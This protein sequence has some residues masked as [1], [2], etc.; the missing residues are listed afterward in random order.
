MPR[1]N[2]VDPR[3]KQLKDHFAAITQ[4]PRRA[5]HSP[6]VAQPNLERLLVALRLQSDHLALNPDEQV[7]HIGKALAL[8]LFIP[9]YQ[10]VPPDLALLQGLVFF[11][12]SYL[13]PISAA[14]PAPSIA[15]VITFCA[16]VSHAREFLRQ[17]KQ[18][19]NA[20]DTLDLETLRALHSLL[21]AEQFGKIVVSGLPH[22]PSDSERRTFGNY[23]NAAARV[24]AL[25][26]EALV[27]EL[28]EERAPREEDHAATCFSQ[29]DAIIP[30]LDT[31]TIKVAVP[32]QVMW[33][34]E[35]MTHASARLPGLQRR[36]LPTMCFVERRLEFQKLRGQAHAPDVLAGASAETM[37]MAGFVVGELGSGRTAF[38]RFLTRQ[39][40]GQ[41]LRHSE[42][43]LPFYFSAGEYVI[44]ARNRRSIHDYIAD[45]LLSF[46]GETPGIEELPDLLRA[47]ERAGKLLL[48]IDDLDRLSEADQS[49]VLAQL[50]FS[51]AVLCA[52]LPWQV[53]RLAQSNTRAHLGVTSF[54]P[55][56]KDEQLALLEHVATV[57]DV[58]YDRRT[59]EELLRELPA[60]AQTP[61]GVM[62]MLDQLARDW[63]D[64]TRVAGAALDELCRR[65]GLPLAPFEGQDAAT[66]TE[67]MHL[68]SAA[69]DLLFTLQRVNGYAGLNGQCD[70]TIV[71]EM[72]EN[73]RGYAW[74]Q[75]WEQ[76]RHTGLF[77]PIPRTTGQ[78][79][80]LIHRDLTCYLLAHAARH[81][82]FAI[83]WRGRAL[84]P[85]A[86]AMLHQV[87]CHLERLKN[88]RRGFDIRYLTPLPRVQ[89]P[90]AKPKTKS[91]RGFFPEIFRVLS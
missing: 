49:E 12:H 88:P 17:A 11:W 77:R 40:A 86:V 24:M 47:V 90:P 19:V 43:I 69:F 6:L 39:Y 74:T 41:F 67:W 7:R 35:W 85:E 36:N 48:L 80:A 42:G 52:A 32:E 21:S 61:L 16:D 38:L 4:N 60:L 66:S 31:E 73:P 1:A 22:R 54:A 9:E 83:Q 51:P 62:T 57:T 26:L 28:F 2:R 33:I 89:P 8:S 64:S 58:V 44:H 46:G 3:A 20:G 18:W 91:W 71:R 63:T 14:Q 50:T 30:Q 29:K 10:K 79:L 59:A 75:S 15:S 84:H 27:P 65:A 25:R 87:I 76:V 5:K 72:V 34:A 45:T 68:Q 78:A 23:L 55:L 70:V 81:H 37:G 82:D 53:T 56:A 13:D